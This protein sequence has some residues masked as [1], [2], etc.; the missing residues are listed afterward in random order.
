LPVTVAVMLQFGSHR[1]QWRRQI[2]ILEGG[3][4]AQGARFTQE[5]RQIVPRVVD[6]LVAP[7]AARMIRHD[8]T[9]EKYDDPI[10]I[11]TH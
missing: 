3:T 8:F 11:G 2:P 4:I 7:E 5:N 9:L 1:R 6:D 10:G